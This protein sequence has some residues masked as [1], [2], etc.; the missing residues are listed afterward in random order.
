MQFSDI[1][2]LA[3]VKEKM[4]H[5]VNSGHVAHAQMIF[6]K[7]GSA[8]LALAM[9]YAQFLNCTNRQEHDSCGECP[10][11]SK[12]Q[13]MI[14][15]DLHFIYPSA[16]TKEVPKDVLSSKFIAHWRELLATNYYPTI[17]EW[18]AHIGA[19]NKQANISVDESRHLIRGMALKSFEA[20][21]K[22]VIIWLPEYMNASASNSILKLLEEPPEKT[23]FILVPNNMD[24]ILTTILSRC[25]IFKVRS[26]H[27]EEIIEELT[28]K[29]GI[30]K[31][32]AAHIASLV[33]GD[34]N[35]AISL[36]SE[37]NTDNSQ[38]FRDWMRR[39]YTNNFTELVAMADSFHAFTKEAQ[40][41]FLQYSQQILR[42]TLI[43]KLDVPAV[44]RTADGDKDF[45]KKFSTSLS[46]DSIA[47]INE[48]INEAQ[49]NIQRNA[50]PKITFL[51]LS[52]QICRIVK[53]KK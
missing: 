34:M 2:G 44:S 39:C 33:D 36:T 3:D 13:K 10:S 8:N 23:L 22:V 1:A 24:R 17:H 50:S 7:E 49:H 43:A 20:E 21:Y 5:A 32:V 40:K 31:D 42:E 47:E 46:E 35:K 25:Q 4:V 26:F 53:P 37:T 41:I 19:E 30:E 51:D 48:L 28:S 27:D 6:G 14:H 16:V 15:P 9:A 11:C 52:F 18:Y 12:Y 38:N 29:H 45:V